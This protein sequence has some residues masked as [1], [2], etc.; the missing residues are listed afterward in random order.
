MRNVI[1]TIF[2]TLAA[3][4]ICARGEELLVPSQ[5]PT[6]QSAIDAAVDGD[7]VIVAP[8]T[9]TGLGNYKIDFLGKSI[10]VRST[11]PN[12]PNIVA[13]TIID[14]NGVTGFYFQN[15]EDA[16]SILDGVT[17]TKGFD[18]NSRGIYCDSSSPTISHCIIMGNSCGI[19]CFGSNAIITGCTITGNASYSGSGIFCKNSSPTISRCIITANSGSGIHC[20]NSNAVITGC[21]ISGNSTGGN[22]GGISCDNSSPTITNCIITDNDVDVGGGGGI[23]GCGGPITNCT[24]AGNSIAFFGCI[25]GGGLADCSGSVTNC[26][27]WGNWPDQIYGNYLTFMITYSD[28]QG[29]YPGLGNIDADP[30]FVDADAN[31]YHLK[32]AGWS[33]DTKRS[34]WTYDDVTSRCIDAG[35]PGSLLGDELLAV[36]RDPEN[37]WGQNLRIDMGSFGGTAEASIPPYDWALLSDL[38]ND[39]LV[40]LVDFA[41]QAADWLN[42]ADQ[43]PGDLNRDS[44]IDIY[45]LALLIEDWLSQTSWH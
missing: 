2:L 15:G 35:N 14:C 38:T 34:C 33:W 13:A 5:Y 40:D 20:W 44:L 32:S 30:C 19:Y 16:N 18:W 17:I 7:T 3:P 23:Y 26:I 31:D 43:Q 4:A 22:G 25:S 42:S 39:G 9:Y 41:Y 1:I 37:I 11:N 24:I 10:T 21:T 6:I 36:P 8:G 28:V 29:G 12:D 27:I 45:D